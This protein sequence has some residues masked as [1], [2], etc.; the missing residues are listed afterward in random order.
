MSRRS[1]DP[2]TESNP[3]ALEATTE[4]LLKIQASPHWLVV[5]AYVTGSVGLAIA[6]F[7]APFDPQGNEGVVGIGLMFFS[8]LV[9][10]YLGLRSPEY[11][12]R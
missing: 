9:L 8:F 5:I 1:H 6:L 12:G 3:S 2:E 4:L 7:S 11:G 10:F